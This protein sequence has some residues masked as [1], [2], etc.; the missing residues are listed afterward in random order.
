MKKWILLVA[1]IVGLVG[2]ASEPQHKEF[3][4]L[5]EEDLAE[6]NSIS[7]LHKDPLQYD[8]SQLEVKNEKITT[9]AEA[10]KKY[11]DYLWYGESYVLDG[12]GKCDCHASGEDGSRPCYFYGKDPAKRMAYAATLDEEN[13]NKFKAK[14]T[15]K[16]VIITDIDDWEHAKYH[17]VHAEDVYYRERNKGYEHCDAKITVNVLVGIPLTQKQ[18]A[19]LL[20]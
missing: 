14:Y 15:G 6:F 1:V 20:F 10:K 12:K 7:P 3:F 4:A 8:A 5:G 16:R 19:L 2:C 9:V 18:K 17:C 11:P 13:L